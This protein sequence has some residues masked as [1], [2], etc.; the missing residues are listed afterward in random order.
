MHLCYSSTTATDDTH[1]ISVPSYEALHDAAVIHKTSDMTQE[2]YY[3]TTFK[4]FK[5]FS[6]YYY[7]IQTLPHTS[8]CT[9][10]YTV[11]TKP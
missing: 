10:T 4:I 2:L 11:P 3:V 5:S 6:H 9:P 8:S 7:Y 1:M